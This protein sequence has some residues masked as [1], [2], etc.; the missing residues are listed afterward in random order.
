[1]YALNIQL[2]KITVYLKSTGEASR[3]NVV[4]TLVKMHLRGTTEFLELLFKKFQYGNHQLER[5]Y[6]NMQ[7]KTV[8]RQSSVASVEIS[9]LIKIE[10]Y[11][12]SQRTYTLNIGSY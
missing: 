4:C 3:V 11:N 1:M 2:L 7:L 10:Q 8:R 12:A 6:V 5:K 9:N